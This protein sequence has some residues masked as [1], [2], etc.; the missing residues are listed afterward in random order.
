VEEN[1][2]E[3]LLRGSCCR[4]EGSSCLHPVSANSRDDEDDEDVQISGKGI[5]RSQS[6]AIF[7]EN[8]QSKSRIHPRMDSPVEWRSSS[9]DHFGATL[10]TNSIS[11]CLASKE[12]RTTHVVI[13]R[14]TIRANSARPS[15]FESYSLSHLEVLDVATELGDDS[16]G[17]VSKNHGFFND[18]IS[19]SSFFA[20]FFRNDIS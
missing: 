15:G 19:D 13:S 16:S 4:E 10:F 5:E 17:L 14:F 8:D 18:E 12:G 3:L 1:E 2:R 20:C 7:F 6:S 9:E 11:C